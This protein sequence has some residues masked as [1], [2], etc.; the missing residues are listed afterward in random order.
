MKKGMLSGALLVLLGLLVALM[1]YYILPVCPVHAGAMTMRCFWTARAEL[2]LGA[3]VAAVGL[4][5]MLR[6]SSPERRTGRE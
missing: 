5:T 6:R 4:F 1:P 3:L 2:I